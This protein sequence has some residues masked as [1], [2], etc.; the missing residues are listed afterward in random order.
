[1]TA[2]Q[3]SSIET[4]IAAVPPISVAGR[5]QNLKRTTEFWSRAGNVYAKYKVAQVCRSSSVTAHARSCCR[6]V[7][8]CRPL[9]Y[10]CKLPGQALRISML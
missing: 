6:S 3:L 8:D 7:S 2:A 4:E 5:W 10:T 1:M 9:L